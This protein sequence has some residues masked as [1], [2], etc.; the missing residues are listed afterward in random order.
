[1]KAGAQCEGTRFSDKNSQ[2][3]PGVDCEVAM[4]AVK[5]SCPLKSNDR[6]EFSM[7]VIRK[8]AIEIGLVAV[9]RVETP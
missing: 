1:M 4:G 6:N 2:E 3:A 9:S 8:A 7:A 5:L